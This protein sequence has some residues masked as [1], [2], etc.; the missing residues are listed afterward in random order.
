MV[1]EAGGARRLDGLVRRMVRLIRLLAENE[2]ENDGHQA[3]Q[4]GQ[5]A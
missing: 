2:R 1:R 4:Q 5:A 3:A